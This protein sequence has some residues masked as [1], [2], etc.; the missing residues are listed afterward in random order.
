MRY[1]VTMDPAHAPTMNDDV[2]RNMVQFMNVPTLRA[3]GHS[4]PEHVPWIDTYLD[5]RFNEALSPYVS[6]TSAFRAQMRLMGAVI[7]GSFA[8]AFLLQNDSRAFAPNDVDVY[9]PLQFGHRFALYL[10]RVE[11]YQLVKTSRVPY[12]RLVAHQTVFALKKGPRRIDV[13]PSSNDC[14]LYPITHFW[15]S[16]LMNFLSADTYC[17][18]Y[19]DLTFSG[20]SVLSPF[21]LIQYRHP[22][23][24]VADLIQKYELRGY[25][26]RVRPYAWDEPPRTTGCVGN[27]ACPRVRRF[28]GDRFCV[29]GQLSRDRGDSGFV[30]KLPSEQTAYWWRGGDACGDGCKHDGMF[31]ERK[32]PSAGLLDELRQQLRRLSPHLHTFHPPLMEPALM[33][34]PIPYRVPPSAREDALYMMY[35]GPTLATIPNETR[36][37]FRSADLAVLYEGDKPVPISINGAVKKSSIFYAEQA[38]KLFGPSSAVSVT[39]QMLYEPDT[40]TQ[41]EDEQKRGRFWQVYDGTNAAG[42]ST[43]PTIHPGSINAGDFV[44]VTCNLVLVAKVFSAPKYALHLEGLTILAL[45]PDDVASVL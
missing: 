21:Q 41:S 2:L 8:L 12:G 28:F 10:V 17:V 32:F 13:I 42:P 11:G 31:P 25:D 36:W 22:S 24:Y 23:A 16:H 5:L 40:P 34:L 4:S 30:R 9:L 35:D 15:A 20:R 37:V 1:G 18:A 39:T 44:R 38:Q 27:G 33:D 26:F 19:P 29:K 3:F 43:L 6:D 45:Q 7:S 14:S